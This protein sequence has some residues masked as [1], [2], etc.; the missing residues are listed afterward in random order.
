MVV[1]VMV[2]LGDLS[3]KPI[4]ADKLLIFKVSLEINLDAQPSYRC[5]Q[6]I[7]VSSQRHMPAKVV[8]INI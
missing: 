4:Q 3:A 1:R 2:V 8:K 7:E 5:R 6:I